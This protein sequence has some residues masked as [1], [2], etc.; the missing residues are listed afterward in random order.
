MLKDFFGKAISVG[1]SFVLLS[2]ADNLSIVRKFRTV[3]NKV[4]IFL[5]FYLYHKKER[6]FLDTLSKIS[7]LLKQKG[8]T[9]KDLTD[10]LGLVKNAF[11][12]WKSGKSKSYIAHIS[13][14][15][16]YLEVSSD[17]LLGIEPKEKAL[18]DESE[19]ALNM[20]EQLDAEQKQ[21]ILTMMR[22]LQD[23]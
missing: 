23:K 21:L 1:V 9:Q 16:E 6:F 13:K 4:R 2:S 10:F 14:I 19:K 5:T 22:N 17:Y 18:S 8:K 15:A 3:N 11:T 7:N 20:F 12:D